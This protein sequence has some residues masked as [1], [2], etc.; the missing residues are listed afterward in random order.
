MPARLV[1][2]LLSLL[3]ASAWG[4]SVTLRWS[5]DDGSLERRQ[6]IDRADAQLRDEFRRRG[7]TVLV[8]SA[9]RDGLLLEPHLEVSPTGLSLR[10]VTVRASDRTLLGTV[11]LRGSGPNRERLLQAL[12]RRA[13]DEALLDLL[14][15]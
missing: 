7:V 14:R 15:R 5:L 9:G 1:C 3:A 6:L 11:T 13:C 2:L 12:V 4:R 10:L 8:A